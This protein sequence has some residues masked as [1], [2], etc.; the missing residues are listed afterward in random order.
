[1][2]FHTNNEETF[3]LLWGRGLDCATINIALRSTY[4]T[5]YLVRVL[6]GMSSDYCNLWNA[7]LTGELRL[8]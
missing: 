7:A 4:L 1:M 3:R 2:A 5:M 8:S 6:S